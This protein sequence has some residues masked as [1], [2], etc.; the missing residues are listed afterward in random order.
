[1]KRRDTVSQWVNR[2]DLL[3][4]SPAWVPV[5]VKVTET[6]GRKDGGWPGLVGGECG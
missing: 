2:E 6:E 4:D 3:G 5:G 1:V